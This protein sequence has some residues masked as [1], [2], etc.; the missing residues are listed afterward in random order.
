MFV[1]LPYMVECNQ[2]YIKSHLSVNHACSA[3]ISVIITSVLK[4]Q[5]ATQCC[6]NLKMDY[7]LTT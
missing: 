2:K 3:I 5:I 7:V 4:V 6:F 1:T